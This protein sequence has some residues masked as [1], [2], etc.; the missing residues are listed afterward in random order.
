[1][2]SR[3]P[4]T[5]G[6][7]LTL[8]SVLVS[9]GTAC[10]AQTTP[11]SSTPLD[12]G[13][14]N[15]LDIAP[16]G[17]VLRPDLPPDRSPSETQFLCT[18]DKKATR[19][20]GVLWPERRPIA[21]VELR[22]PEG[23]AP[24]PN[25]LVL[26]LFANSWW[27]GQGFITWNTKGPQPTILPY[28][29]IGFDKNTLVFQGE[30]PV[31]ACQLNLRHKATVANPAVP[32]IHV[33]SGSRFS[34]MK[35]EV[36]WGLAEGQKGQN[37][38]GSIS[39]YNG[40]VN[41]ARPLSDSSGVTMT[42]DY[43]WRAAPVGDGRQGLVIDVLYV[44]NDAVEMT[45]GNTYYPNR[46][47]VTIQTGHGGFS[48]AP[49]DLET[50][51]IWAPGL[52]V[53]IT[54]AG[55]EPKGREYARQ[56]AS[57]HP[58][59]IRQT[60]RERD[61]QT[62][63]GALEAYFGKDR[64]PIPAPGDE[65]KDKKTLDGVRLEPGMQFS[66]PDPTV[67]AAFRLAY[68]H[69]KRRC[70][71]KEPDGS[72]FITDFYYPPIGFECATIFEAM[73]V[74]GCEESITRTGFNPW[75]ADQGKVK[76]LSGLWKDL[77]G[78]LIR[79]KPHWPDWATGENG[80]QQEEACTEG[81]YAMLYVLARHY[82]LTGDNDWLVKHL[83]NLKAAGEWTIRQRHWW[84]DRVGPTSWS[85]G[86]VPPSGTGDFDVLID[87]WVG[88]VTQ[89][90]AYNALKAAGEA[91]AEFDPGTGARFLK[92]A[93]EHR[94]AVHASVAKSV[95]FSPLEKVRD[96][97]YRRCMPSTAYLH[98]LVSKS[99]NPLE[100]GC[101]MDARVGAQHLLWNVFPPND[102]RFDEHLD[103]IEDNFYLDESQ[104]NDAWFSKPLV[105]NIGLPAQCAMAM[106][107]LRKDDVPNFLR[108][109]FNQYACEI[110][111]QPKEIFDN[112]AFPTFFRPVDPKRDATTMYLFREGPTG[113]PDKIQETAGFVLRMRAMLVMEDADSLWLAR[114]TPR[115]WFEQGK[116]IQ[117]ANA[118]TRF[119]PAGYEIV[120]DVD[121]NRIVAT[122]DVPSRKQP[123]NVLL[124]LRHPKAAPIK[125]VTVDGKPWT[126]FDSG[127][128][129][130]RLHDAKG[131]IRVEAHY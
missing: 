104:P 89:T 128:E 56:W 2:I 55:A 103:V 14:G 102:A 74:M 17:Y 67:S 122:V 52:G 94:Q 60:V 88:H 35:V 114:G 4:L 84:A 5:I 25:D 117:V 32:E 123:K 53:F 68:W 64:P 125:S 93:E 90:W 116:R 131:K 78:T 23:K 83:P 20:G 82:Q 110:L 21:R 130:V 3:L 126:D 96:G 29:S 76:R 111:P 107:H 51:P 62:L 39:A 101:Q 45:P 109:V 42:D 81:T 33:Y 57:K 121:H 44:G 108:T 106:T 40:R 9:C 112:T 72:N 46:S 129:M 10:G 16:F 19:L 24:D 47:V 11:A 118:P 58:P 22:F 73:D 124:R 75:F 27:A 12:A 6:A 61:E 97:S 8:N 87:P 98:G 70:L 105:K 79:V 7:L 95:V 119:G 43:S 100:L 91:I 86:F 31:L 18:S 85:Y 34:T 69:V 115:R 65:V 15:Q 1:M 113:G 41:A 38:S 71:N 50:G 59:T 63:D 120:S 37:N 36:E 13:T 26:E 99:C 66:I 28:V 48:F 54:K 49:K 127:K 30:K 92:E 80:N 77:E